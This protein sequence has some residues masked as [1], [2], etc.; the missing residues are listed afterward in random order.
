[1]RTS[2]GR[3]RSLSRLA[4]GVGRITDTLKSPFGFLFPGNHAEEL[5]AEHI[6]R[7]HHRGRSLNDILSDSYVKNHITDDKVNRVLE[8]QDVIHAIG[9]DVIAAIR[10]PGP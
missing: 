3:R 4:R 5:V 10:G 2:D 9:E 1:M 7:E 6:I 8:R